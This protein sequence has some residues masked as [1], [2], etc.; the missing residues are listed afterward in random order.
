MDKTVGQG[1][2]RRYTQHLNRQREVILRTARSL[3]IRDGITAV[4]MSNIAAGCGIT[5]ATLYRYYRSKE[6]ILWAVYDQCTQPLFERLAPVYHSFSGT[7]F[8]RFAFIQQ[9][10]EDAFHHNPDF[11]LFNDVFNSLYQSVTSDETQ[12]GRY[13]RYH[14]DGLGAKDTVRFLT[15]G[16]FADGSVRAGLDPV[17]TAVAFNYGCIAI[18]TKFTKV[19]GSLPNKYG[20]RPAQ[21]AAFCVQALLDALRPAAGVGAQ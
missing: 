9:S 6:E 12:R 2:Q 16:D 1:P 7:T 19:S 8:E 11:F 10:L 17:S 4:G 20:V 3:F 5:R 14:G 15:A 13:R 21:E 18:Y